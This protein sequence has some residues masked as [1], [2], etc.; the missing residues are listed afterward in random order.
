[1][2]LL[3]LVQF[4]VFYSH[5]SLLYF[6]ISNSIQKQYIIYE[7]VWFGE[8]W[9]ITE[10]PLRH[11]LPI[12]SSPHNFQFPIS[13]KLLRIFDVEFEYIVYL[14]ITGILAC[15]GGLVIYH[16]GLYIFPPLCMHTSI[17]ER[18]L[19]KYLTFVTGPTNIWVITDLLKVSK[20]RIIFQMT[21]VEK[22]VDL[23]VEG[24]FNATKD[25]RWI[26]LSF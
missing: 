9:N 23:R 20:E 5:Y 4:Q 11:L 15:T 13:I 14:S 25:F 24:Q 22:K 2:I 3:I 6:I 10:C 16:F 12:L 26:Q 7:N 8:K 17:Q 18:M 19:I 1:M 21:L